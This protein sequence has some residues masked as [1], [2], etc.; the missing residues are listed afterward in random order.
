MARRH[1]A[2]RHFFQSGRAWS[3]DGYW[4]STNKYEG[5]NTITGP[6]TAGFEPLGNMAAAKPTVRVKALADQ[7]NMRQWQVVIRNNSNKIAF[8][9]QLLLTDENG[10]AVHRTHYSDNFITLLPGEQETI[11]VRTSHTQGKKYRFKFNENM[12]PSKIIAL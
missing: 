4:R 11:L 5:K 6:C 12:Q 3:G 8:F 2:P 10:N 7:D 1:T 9:C